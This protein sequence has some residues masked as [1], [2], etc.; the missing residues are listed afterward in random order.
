MTKK[1]SKVF[2]YLGIAIVDTD[3]HVTLN[4]F[5][6]ST[7]DDYIKDILH[8]A[9]IGKV[10]TIKA[11]REGSYNGQNFGYLVELPDEIK[12]YFQCKIHNLPHITTEVRK[13][14]EPVNTWKCFTGAGKS[15]PCCINFS[16]VVTM[17]YRSGA[18]FN[19]F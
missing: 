15:S 10:V 17:Y 9:P 13:E 5:S 4:Y 18:R 16:G 7:S 11:I 14:G 12:P 3:W 2:G 8:N 19:N 6:N 1:L